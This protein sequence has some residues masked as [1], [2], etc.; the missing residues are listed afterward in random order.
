MNKEK[1][2]IINAFALFLSTPVF[3]FTGLFSL[4]MYICVAFFSLLSITFFVINKKSLILD[5]SH[6]SISFFLLL[7]QIFVLLM[8]STLHQDI[9]SNLNILFQL[10]F[11]IVF[12]CT[13]IHVESWCYKFALY[14]IELLKFL[15]L[16]GFIQFILL[17]FNYNFLEYQFNDFSG[18]EMIWHG[19]STTHVNSF[20]FGDFRFYRMT[21][22]FDE[23]GTAS[24]FIAM[25]VI[26]NQ[27][28]KLPVKNERLLLFYGFF[29]LSLFY[30]LILAVYLI[31]T[32]NFKKTLSILI[33]IVIAFTLI[34]L[35]GYIQNVDFDIILNFLADR[36]INRIVDIQSGDNRADGYS[37]SI[38][39]IIDYPLLGAGRENGFDVVIGTAGYISFFAMFGIIGG[40]ILLL[41]ILYSFGLCLVNKSIPFQLKMQYIFMVL[42]MLSH[43]EHVLQILSYFIF[44]LIIN[45]FRQIDELSIKNT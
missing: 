14:Y 18:H 32:L 10:L 1:L 15:C 29:T 25:A 5:I 4:N 19:I 16:T 27:I 38:G 44:L 37:N 23:P 17:A 26:L 11:L 36:S 9:I 42:I 30:F 24:F 43:R 20:N 33:F 22:Y 40:V 8:H 31:C 3:C 2:L 21:F 7:L 13:V 6:F 45:N 35:V 12:L 28:L 41:H 39:Y 34:L